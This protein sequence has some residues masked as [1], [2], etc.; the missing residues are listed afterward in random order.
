M[1]EIT[2]KRYIERF[3]PI[4]LGWKYKKWFPVD[5]EKLQQWYAELEK[6]YNDWKFIYGQHKYMWIDDPGDSEG[7]TGHRFMDDTSWYT[8]CWNGDRE[9]PLPPE[10][11]HARSEFQDVDEDELYPRKCF[12]G[13]ALDI[14][15][16]LP[17]RSKRW[18]V[19]IHTPGTNLITHQD[20]TD[21][22][23]VHIPIVTNDQ[24]TW[25]IDGEEL[26]MEPGWAY[27]VNTSL[28]HSV[29]NK[30]T[31]NRVHLYGKVWVDD[32]V[33]MKI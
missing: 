14:V 6:N 29:V 10:R 3:E 24:S 8:L 9:G 16:S 22:I 32:I 33:K 4:D 15:R 30:G 1:T 17:I 12:D 26:H 23:R 20:A 13:Y 2:Y 21:K 19:T 31:T 5:S 28:P 25:I 11:G 27:L 18:L 7:I